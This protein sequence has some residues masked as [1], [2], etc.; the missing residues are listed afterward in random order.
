MSN[1]K[2]EEKGREA[3]VY[4]T[5]LAEKSERFDGNFNFL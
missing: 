1:V 5:K 4:L 3:Y 2:S